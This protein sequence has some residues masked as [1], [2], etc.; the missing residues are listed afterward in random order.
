MRRFFP[1]VGVALTM[2]I[3]GV[4][5]IFVFVV[6]GLMFFTLSFVAMVACLVPGQRAARIDPVAALRHE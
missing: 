6:P 5:G 3:I 4:L 2:S 1:V